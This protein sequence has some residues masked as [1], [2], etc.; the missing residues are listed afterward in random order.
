MT[1][2][3]STIDPASAARDTWDAA[4][5]GAGPAGSIAALHLARAGARVLVIERRLFPRHK[6]CGDCLGALGVRALGE[7]GVSGVLEGASVSISEIALRAHGACLSAPTGG[8]RAVPREHLDTELLR[9]A[10]DA[11]A[12]AIIGTRAELTGD[13]LIRVVGDHG[14][15]GVRASSVV[16][17]CGL[18]GRTGEGTPRARVARRSLIG[19]G[20]A[21]APSPSAPPRGRLDMIVARGG[22][23]G[24]VRLADGREN[25]GAAL[26]P[27]ATRAVGGITPAI[28]AILA[29]AGLDPAHAPSAG[30]AGTPALTRCRRVEVGRV[31]L[32]GDAAGYVEP[33]TGEGMS[34]ALLTGRAAAGHA[35]SLARGVHRPGAWADEHRRL[36]S[37]R[38]RR[39][40]AVAAL[41]RR[42]GLLRAAI[43]A[44]ACIPASGG[45]VRALIGA[46]AGATT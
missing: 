14:A 18:E 9:A 30:W 3:A 29:S 27:D 25:W 33:I 31:L 44:A 1:A 43:T 12:D 32:A 36:T 42:P 11:G 24:R 8:M 38:R 15:H 35:L 28:G 22:Y 19:V 10:I 26:S 23:L 46:R 6:V 7:A 21:C 17:A 37:A 13:G 40:A 41:V 20:A 2:P 4:V 5:I 39:C 34:W 45:V 16:L